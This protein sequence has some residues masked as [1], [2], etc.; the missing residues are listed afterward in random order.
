VFLIHFSY[1]YTYFVFFN[2]FSLI[3][4]LSNNQIQRN[5]F[6]THSHP[7]CNS[8][9]LIKWMLTFFFGKIKIQKKID[10]GLKC[11]TR[12]IRDQNKIKL[13]GEQVT[14]KRLPKFIR[15]SEKKKLSIIPSTKT[16]ITMGREKMC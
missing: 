2:Y 5:I 7:F 6:F 9:F 10:K 14:K 3:V 15:P 13:L 8:W 1:L 11:K 16:I 12:K 4:V